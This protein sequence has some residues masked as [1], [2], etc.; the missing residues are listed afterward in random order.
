MTLSSWDIVPVTLHY[1]TP[2][3]ITSHHT[4]PHHIT[5]HHTT[6][7]STTPHHTTPHHTTPHHTTP[8][9]TA[10]HHTTPHRTAPHHTTPHHITS[11]HIT[12]HHITSHYIT[13]HHITLHSPTYMH[14]IGNPPSWWSCEEFW[15]HC[16]VPCRWTPRWIWRP[17]TATEIWSAS[18]STHWFYNKETYKLIVRPNRQVRKNAILV[19]SHFF[20]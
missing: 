7:H 9:H 11:H 10:P 16:C 14:N 8:H 12:S 13:S 19:S 20:S 17:A 6:P 1:I 18:W 15:D 5:P 2:H 3:H 4:T